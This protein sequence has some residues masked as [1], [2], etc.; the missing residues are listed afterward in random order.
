MDNL[1][2]IWVITLFISYKKC[3]INKK[4]RFIKGDV[5]DIKYRYL[6]YA[7]VNVKKQLFYTKIH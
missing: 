4:C 1:H 5:F 3:L 7:G 2:K 6:Y